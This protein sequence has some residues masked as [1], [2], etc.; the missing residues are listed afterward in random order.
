MPATKTK[1]T[2]RQASKSLVD[3]YV[4]VPLGAGQLFIEKSKELSGAAVTFAK[5]RTKDITK[6]YE[7]LAKRGEKIA[8][9][10]R[11]S[12]YTKRAIEQTD[13]ARTQVKGTVRSVRRAADATAEATRAAARKV[14]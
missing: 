6:S 7:S 10:I 8:S 3:Y 12:A 4:Y 5:G 1:T 14:V 13:K 9:S 11:R 2:K